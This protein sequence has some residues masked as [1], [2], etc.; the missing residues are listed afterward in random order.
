MIIGHKLL[1]HSINL[2]SYAYV[3][4]AKYTIDLDSD[5]DSDTLKPINMKDYEEE[6]SY[7]S[8]GDPAWTPFELVSTFF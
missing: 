4:A 2:S 8:D 5:S 6:E 7:D 1:L 3:F